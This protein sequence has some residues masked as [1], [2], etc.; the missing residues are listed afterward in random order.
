MVHAISDELSEDNINDSEVPQQID[1][2][3]AKLKDNRLE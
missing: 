1:D 2:K 3:R